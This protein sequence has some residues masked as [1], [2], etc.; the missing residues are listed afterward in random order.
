M[1]DTTLLPAA[2]G[3][4]RQTQI[5]ACGMLTRSNE[6][7]AMQNCMTDTPGLIHCYSREQLLYSRN[8]DATTTQS[9]DVLPHSAITID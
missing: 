3:E 4:Q 8:E 1:N 9:R 7:P 6:E 5:V 2:Q